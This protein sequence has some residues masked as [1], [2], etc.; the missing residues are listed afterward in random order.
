MKFNFLFLILA[1]P[2]AT[3][4]QYS[5]YYGRYDVNSTVNVTGSV[6]KTITTIDYG[7]LAIANAE[8]EK[9]RLQSL[10]YS[11]ELER[12]QALEIA[13]NPMKAFDYGVDGIGEGRGRDA[14]RFGFNKLTLYHKVPHSSLFVRTSGYSYRNISDNNIITEVELYGPAKVNDIK[15]NEE[16]K[17]KLLESYKELLE[18]PEEFVQYTN[19]KIGAYIKELDA[20]LHKK[21]I[22]KAK[23]WNVDGYKVSLFYENKYEYVIEDKYFAS[24][25][26]IIYRATVCYK[27]DKDEIG[28][29]DLE[30][31]R[32]YL[33]RL[34]DQIIA[35][36]FI[37]DAK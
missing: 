2:F 25:D 35:T 1:L 27:G 20:F 5:N 24:V 29:E 17:S 10:Q 3:Y 12:Q 26:G 21:D 37:K 8:R 14:Q 34:C 31:R 16:I 32:Y 22:N 18:N 11:N 6:T 9:N 23:V 4:G 15:N 33:R 13:L 7:S 36:A 28:F 19:Y 30:G